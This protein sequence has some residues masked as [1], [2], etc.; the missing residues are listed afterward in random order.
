MLHAWR[1]D[2]RARMDARGFRPFN[3]VWLLSAARD[4][5]TVHTSYMMYRVH[6]LPPQIET[7]MKIYRDSTYSFRFEGQVLTEAG[8]CSSDLGSCQHVRGP[9]SASAVRPSVRLSC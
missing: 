8:S 1:R 6:A 4:I 7:N 3:V 5:A 9:R 2:H